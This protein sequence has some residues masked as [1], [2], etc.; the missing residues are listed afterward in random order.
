MLIKISKIFITLVL[1]SNLLYSK[2]VLIIG[3]SMAEA[4]KNPISLIFANNGIVT[5]THFKRGT[6][7]DFWLKNYEVF[8]NDLKNADFVIVTLGTNDLFSNKKTSRIIEE[9]EQLEKIL[10]QNNLPRGAIFYISTPLKND[11]MIF[12]ALKNKFGERV[13]DSKSLNLGM[14][15]DNVHPMMASNIL[16][17][18]LI[19][20]RLSNY[21]NF[22]KAVK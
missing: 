16:W 9:L 14:S 4:I 19:V 5:A 18:A 11:M 21:D 22:L 8:A 13:F 10:M 6:R 7:V 2:N 1:L 3:D 12:E 17:S 20:E 15:K